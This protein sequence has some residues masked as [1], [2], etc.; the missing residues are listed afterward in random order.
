MFWYISQSAW[1]S[2]FEKSA[3]FLKAVGM[4][5]LLKLHLWRELLKVLT[6]ASSK[7]FV[8]LSKRPVLPSLSVLRIHIMNPDPDTGFLVNVDPDPGVLRTKNCDFFLKAFLEDLKSTYRQSLKALQRERPA[9][10]NLKYR[11][12]IFWAIFDYQDPA[13]WNRNRN[14]RNRNFLASGTGTVTC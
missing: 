6:K 13:L 5:N 12:F 9:L 8:S 1:Q 4:K 2:V 3:I 10:Q 14:R 11:Y 7:Y